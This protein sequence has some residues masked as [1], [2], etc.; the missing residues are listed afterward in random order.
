MKCS[1]FSVETGVR[2]CCI[3]WTNWEAQFVSNYG[4]PDDGTPGVPKHGGM[5]QCYDCV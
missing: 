2:L 3:R 1:R 5:T 4:F